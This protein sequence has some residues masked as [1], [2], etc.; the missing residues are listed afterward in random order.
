MPTTVTKSV[1]EAAPSSVLHFYLVARALTGKHATTFLDASQQC[2]IS[3]SR[4]TRELEKLEGQLGKKALFVSSESSEGR[5]TRTPR[6]TP[7]GREL[8]RL[9]APLLGEL[10]EHCRQF[11]GTQ[12]SEVRIAAPQA[13]IQHEVLP[14]LARNPSLMKLRLVALQRPTALTVELVRDRTIEIGIV[15]GGLDALLGDFPEL[16]NRQLYY[17]TYKRL[18]TCLLLPPSPERLGIRIGATGTQAP[19]LEQI[20]QEPLVLIG[21]PARFREQIDRSFRRRKLQPDIRFQADSG[22]SLVEA[23]NSGL[24]LAILHSVALPLALRDSPRVIRLPDG[25]FGRNELGLLSMCDEVLSEPAKRLLNAL[26][27]GDARPVKL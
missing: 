18:F 24:G 23:C 9:V 17:S 5:K 7:A 8:F 10:L 21:E 15:S 20:A 12:A 6:L 26:R 11:S 25:M 3:N 16:Q 1:F 14:A 13:V 2:G 19:T 27:P 4:L 22:A